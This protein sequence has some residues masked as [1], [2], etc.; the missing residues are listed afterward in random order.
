M[1]ELFGLNILK[2]H[3]ALMP[4]VAICGTACVMCASYIGYMVTRKT[5]LSF[6]PRS[7]ASESAPYQSVGATEIRKMIGH[8]NPLVVDPKIEALKRELG[9]YK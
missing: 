9:S 5:D 1:P 4:V 7:W 8:R 6:R 2:K 3:W